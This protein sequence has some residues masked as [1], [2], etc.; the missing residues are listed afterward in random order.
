MESGQTSSSRQR[1]CVTSDIIGSTLNES[2]LASWAFSHS[3]LV[4]LANDV[5]GI[6]DGK[7]YNVVTSYKEEGHPWLK[8]D[9]ADRK[10]LERKHF[11]HGIDILDPHHYPDTGIINVF[12]GGIIDDKS[13]CP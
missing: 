4:H 8:E 3:T 6:K 9:S 1:S 7:Q 10:K 2:T 5:D 11:S 12:S 13:Q